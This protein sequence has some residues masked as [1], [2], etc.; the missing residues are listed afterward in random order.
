MTSPKKTSSP[1]P[2]ETHDMSPTLISDPSVSLLPTANFIE[3]NSGGLVTL[4]NTLQ[5]NIDGKNGWAGDKKSP[6]QTE[7]Y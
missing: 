3:P 6:S 5:S 1:P 2:I 4:G 7:V